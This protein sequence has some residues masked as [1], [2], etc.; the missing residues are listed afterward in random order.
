MKALAI[1]KVGLGITA[2][3]IGGIAAPIVDSFTKKDK[4]KAI[5]EELERLH[6]LAEKEIEANGKMS[7]TTENRIRDLVWKLE[8]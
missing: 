7:Y 1:I 4:I 5:S 2:L 3:L 6:K 8:R